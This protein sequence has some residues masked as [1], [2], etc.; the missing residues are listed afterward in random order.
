MSSTNKRTIL[1]VVWL[2]LLGGVYF[3]ISQLITPPGPG[4]PPPLPPEFSAANF[5][6]KWPDIV[7]HFAAPP[8]GSPTAPY[9]LVEFGDFQCPQCGKL[10]PVI[11][12]LQQNSAGRVNLYF[13]HRPFPVDQ[14][15]NPMHK[16]AVS[17]AE[18]SLAAAAQGKFWPM[19]DVLYQN[20]DDLE[21]GYYNDYAAQ[22]G[23]DVKRFEA[24]MNAHKYAAP[25][26]ESVR[27]TDALGMRLTPTV[28]VRDN[29]TGKITPYAGADSTQP[30]AVPGF[31]GL[32]QLAENPPWLAAPKTAHK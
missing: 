21:P 7:K 28:L 26:Q 9:T 17:A 23:L 13:V 8:K 30:T 10:R 4:K 18:A 12:S 3:V 1:L 27:F 20:Q 6:K 25:A 11:E 32:K 15:G 19:Y 16:Y 29:A 14:A 5:E 2:A 31:P 24:D 22:A